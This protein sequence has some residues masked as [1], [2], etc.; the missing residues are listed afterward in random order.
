V[1]YM[2][3]S[4]C[5]GASGPECPYLEASIDKFGVATLLGS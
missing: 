5:M 3:D 1:D 4:G 2:I